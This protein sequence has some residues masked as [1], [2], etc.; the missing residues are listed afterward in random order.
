MNSLHAFIQN[1]TPRLQQQQQQPQQRR[2]QQT[3]SP[4][5]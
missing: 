3:P 5:L 2:Q 4:Q 1:S